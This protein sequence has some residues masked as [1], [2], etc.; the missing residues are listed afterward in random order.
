[1]T[2]A[3]GAQRPALRGDRPDS[4]DGVRRRSSGGLL[5]TWSR[6]PGVVERPQNIVLNKMFDVVDG[7]AQDTHVHRILKAHA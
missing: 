4:A 3:S 1:M 2:S 7:I 6:L 5:K